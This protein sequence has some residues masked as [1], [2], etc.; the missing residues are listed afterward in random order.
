MMENL[1]IL[2]FSHQRLLYLVTMNYFILSV[3]VHIALSIF[4]NQI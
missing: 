3:S 2:N 4:V 1:E